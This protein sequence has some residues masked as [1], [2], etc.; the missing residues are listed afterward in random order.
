MTQS[1]HYVYPFRRFS[2]A[3]EPSRIPIQSGVILIRSMQ[4]KTDEE[5]LELLAEMS[6]ATPYEYQHIALAD[7]TSANLDTWEPFVEVCTPVSQS[8]PIEIQRFFRGG[9]A[10]CVLVPCDVA[11]SA[12][13]EPAS[14]P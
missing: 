4:P 1:P 10:C 11:D 8:R 2:T 5:L 13:I 12:G 6:V 14:A 9:D 7:D 3:G